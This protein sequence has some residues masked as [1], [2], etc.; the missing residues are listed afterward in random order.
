MWGAEAVG[1]GWMAVVLQL[2]LLHFL[3]WMLDC[4]PMHYSSPWPS[5]KSTIT[6]FSGWKTE[7]GLLPTKLLPRVK[8]ALGSV[9]LSTATENDNSFLPHQPNAVSRCIHVNPIEVRE[10][11]N[12]FEGSFWCQE[13][14][15]MKTS[16]RA[17]A[18]VCACACVYICVCLCAHVGGTFLPKPQTS[19]V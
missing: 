1:V 15:A 10:A 6:L 12:T 4:S 8:E 11:S 9:F 18:W 7:L 16:S 14:R 17:R 5:A 3:L 2:L 13:S 19:I